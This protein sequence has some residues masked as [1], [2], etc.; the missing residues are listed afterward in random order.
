M[1]FFQL[2]WIACEIACD[3]LSNL[4]WHSLILELVVFHGYR[5][6]RTNLKIWAP[7]VVKKNTP[8]PFFFLHLL[9]YTLIHHLWSKLSTCIPPKNKKFSQHRM[10]VS[11]TPLIFVF[12]SKSQ[13]VLN[14]VY[15]IH[16]I[17]FFYCSYKV[18]L[19][20]RIHMP[21]EFWISLSGGVVVF[22]TYMYTI[23]KILS[24]SMWSTS[25]LLLIILAI[26][27][28]GVVGEY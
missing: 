26:W 3:L 15:V 25:R 27:W 11:L 9:T 23:G 12:L 17:A 5:Q 20:A 7:K 4:F 2:W 28:Y 19:F 10:I 8:R 14:I 1:F 16:T 6:D 18:T 21:L 24:L 13:H 22:R